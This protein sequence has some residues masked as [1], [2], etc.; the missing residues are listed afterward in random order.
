MRRMRERMLNLLHWIGQL[1]DFRLAIEDVHV[2]PF[3]VQADAPAVGGDNLKHSV[4]GCGRD[5]AGH[6]NRGTILQLCVVV[7]RSKRPSDSSRRRPA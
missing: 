7:I 2:Q 5:T 1:R 6:L 4:T 3:L